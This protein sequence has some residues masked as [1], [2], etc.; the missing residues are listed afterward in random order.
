MEP[1]FHCGSFWIQKCEP[2]EAWRSSEIPQD[3]K[4]P[5]LSVLCGW[6]TLISKTSQELS[7]VFCHHRKLSIAM[8]LFLS[9]SF[10][11]R[12]SAA[13]DRRK[14]IT[15]FRERFFFGEKYWNIRSA[16]KAQDKIWNLNCNL[17]LLQGFICP[18]LCLPSSV[19]PV[20][21]LHLQNC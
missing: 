11:W 20:L 3:W 17:E 16:K 10:N 12:Q 2:E 8:N 14:K 4:S 5:S 6:G 7:S 9:N 18:C 19:K 13:M 1:I 21:D 15:L